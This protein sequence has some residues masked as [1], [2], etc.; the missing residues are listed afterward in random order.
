ME[1]TYTKTYM[2]NNSHLY[3]AEMRT[4]LSNVRSSN[5]RTCLKDQSKEIF[6]IE[7]YT[8]I[9]PKKIVYIQVLSCQNSGTEF[10]KNVYEYM[11]NYRNK[12]ILHHHI[13][14]M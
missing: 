12:Y 2:I 10:F 5:D 1:V 11:S 4:Q 3:Y 13:A 9:E 8:T 6:T 7:Q 14:Y